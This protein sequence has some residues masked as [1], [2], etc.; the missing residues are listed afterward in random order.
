MKNIIEDFVLAGFFSFYNLLD[1]HSTG[2]CQC[3]GPRQTVCHCHPGWSRDPSGGCGCS[4]AQENCRDPFTQAS[5]ANWPK[6][7][8]NNSKREI[9]YVIC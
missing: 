4:L 9:C 2:D 1:G 5:V 7:Q 3:I 8:L 6:S